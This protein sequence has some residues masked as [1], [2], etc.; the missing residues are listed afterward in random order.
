MR[1]VLLVEGHTEQAFIQHL[2][3]YLSRHLSPM[4]KLEVRPYHGRVPTGGA[5]REAVQDLLR[6]RQ[7]P[8]GHVI[9][10]T[11][12]YTGTTPPLFKSADDARG[13][14]RGWVGAEPR[15]HSHAAQY[16]FEAW[17]IPYWNDLRS[18]AGHNQSSPGVN[19]ESINHD[20]PPSKRIKTLFQVGTFRG[21]Y[22]K[23]RDADRIFRKNG[24]DAAIA[25]C[26]E[27][28][29]FINTI[30]TICDADPIP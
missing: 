1:V 7:R 25:Q 6:R 22:S 29:S 3:Q 19:P 26:P 5:L 13:K 10:L 20:N 12:V 14:M 17:L 23:P 15:F 28:K 24:L 8:V 4:P 11:D 21:A 2:R 9:A 30:L 16:D 27:L 18:I